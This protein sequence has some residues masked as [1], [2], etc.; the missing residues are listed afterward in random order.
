MADRGPKEGPPTRYNSFV[1]IQ[2]LRINHQARMTLRSR[3]GGWSGQR[4]EY[5]LATF[6]KT[7]KVDGILMNTLKVWRCR[8][9]KFMVVFP[10]VDR[11]S[12]GVN[13]H[14]ERDL[15][16]VRGGGPRFSLPAYSDPNLRLV[17]PIVGVP[18]AR[19]SALKTNK[20]GIYH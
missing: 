2:H 18:Q 4:N 20:V 6:V 17:H 10:G 13:H 1:T 3:S 9:P 19:N 16:R 5:S 12:R 11:Q 7:N 8:S 14:V 15:C